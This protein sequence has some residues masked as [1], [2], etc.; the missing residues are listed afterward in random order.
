MLIA[1]L[2]ASVVQA[3]VID[4]NSKNTG[5]NHYYR[6]TTDGDHNW[7]DGGA[8]FNMHV[9]TNSWGDTWA[10]FT[11]SDV[12]DTTT[13]GINN[14]YAVYGDG[15]D[16]SDGGV[17]TIGYVDNYNGVKPTI[18]FGAPS[19]VNGLYVN[20]TTYAALDMKNGSGF[21]KAFS[22]NDWFKLTAEGFDASSASLGT[23]DIYLADFTGY[24]DGDNKDDYMVTDWAWMDLSSLGSNVT[25]VA[26]TLTSSDT[27]AWGMNTPAYF[28]MDDVQAVPEPA[29]AVLILGG[30]ASMFA[31]R[32]R[33]FR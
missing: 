17:Y 18:S 33:M 11:Y 26:F 1:L 14:Q 19:L 10:G 28:A 31:F 15:M 13:S 29:S 22:T 30:F 8:G 2:S 9:Y 5:P 4:F 27:G 32:R 25:S 12:N 21:S 3:A 16:R 6:P 20:N 24:S 7:T 23:V